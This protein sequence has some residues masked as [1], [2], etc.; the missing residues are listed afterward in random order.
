M[1]VRAEDRRTPLSP[2]NTPFPGFV[3]GP[4]GPGTPLKAAGGMISVRV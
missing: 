3:G 2:A 4:S 1:S